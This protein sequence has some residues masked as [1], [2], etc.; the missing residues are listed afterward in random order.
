V[1]EKQIII[2]VSAAVAVLCV[3]VW[4]LYSRRQGRDT[5]GPRN[6]A[7]P[8][9]S[10]ANDQRPLTRQ[11][12]RVKRQAQKLIAR[13]KIIPA[14]QMLEQI[15]FYRE[16]I[17]ALENGRLFD[18]AARVLMRL[19]RPGRAGVLYS[20]N[21][22]WEPA[23]QCYLQAGDPLNAAKCFK[24]AG[25]LAEAA[26][27]FVKT[28]QFSDAAECLEKIGHLGEAARN[29]LKMGKTE[30]A[31]DA[32]NKLG[33]DKAMLAVFRPSHDEFDIMFETVKVKSHLTGIV[34]ILS[35]APQASSMILELLSTNSFKTAELL[36]QH[37][38]EHQTSSLIS[39]VNIQSP[40]TPLLVTLFENAGQHRSAAILLEQLERFTEAAKAFKKSGEM[41]RSDYCLSRANPD[42]VGLL[43]SS[44]PNNISE[45]RP[46]EVKIPRANFF[47][48]TESP[49]ATPSSP[50]TD[51]S[52]PARPAPKI[53]VASINTQSSVGP[54][55]GLTIT[56]DEVRLISRSWIFSGINE[57]D[58]ENFIACFSAINL[59]AGH[60]ILSGSRDTFLVMAI[61]G[62]LISP[63]VEDTSDGWLAP[64]SCLA[65]QNPT[66]WKVTS[67]TARVV[68]VKAS[69][70]NA[71]LSG[72]ADLTRIVYTNLTQRL[73][74]WPSKRTILKAI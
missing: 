19:Q 27:L 25:K 73:L 26:E 41:E 14:A 44:A 36:F 13:G 18:D 30:S 45:N 74:Q 33:E 52:N 61:I 40:A 16:A 31:V 20:R 63:A 42:Q 32:W 15:G 1:K 50:S 46:A 48:G 21:G 24:Q 17:D 34:R 56:S 71:I 62:D 29:W 10:R 68:S 43:A 7:V 51:E 58:I 8:N 6:A 23:A 11:E 55:M 53:L 37:T 57:E 5:S 35:R 64:E 22:L 3:V 59:C 9:Q 2:L 47:I 70:F 28:A 12:Q 69:D 49:V 39:D 54:E 65:G 4:N 60:T 72:D 66:A 67:D 38:P